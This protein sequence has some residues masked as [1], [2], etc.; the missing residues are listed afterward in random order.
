MTVVCSYVSIGY[1]STYMIVVVKLYKICS[2]LLEV[3][4]T[5]IMLVQLQ[6]SLSL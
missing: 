5:C 4:A 3:T 2:P 1:S 6:I